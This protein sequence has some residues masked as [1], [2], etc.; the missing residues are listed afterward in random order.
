MMLLAVRRA[1]TPRVVAHFEV[2]TDQR[3]VGRCSCVRYGE[4]DHL[5]FIKILWSQEIR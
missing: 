1:V 2:P 3:A 5:S 4:C